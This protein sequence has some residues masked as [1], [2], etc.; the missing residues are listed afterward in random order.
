MVVDEWKDPTIEDAEYGPNAWGQHV[1]DGFVAY[2]MIFLHR[3]PSGSLS[4]RLPQIPYSEEQSISTGRLTLA[5]VSQINL[6]AS[7]TT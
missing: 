6:P 4:H 1:T 3:M 2:G 5:V 7:Q